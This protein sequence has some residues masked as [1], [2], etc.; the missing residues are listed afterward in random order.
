[1]FEDRAPGWEIGRDDVRVKAVRAL[2]V[3]FE[4]LDEQALEPAAVRLDMEREAAAERLID[5]GHDLPRALVAKP[6]AAGAGQMEIV[7]TLKAL[8]RWCLR[9]GRHT[10]RHRRPADA[11]GEPQPRLP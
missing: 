3:G 1:M 6:P 8:V 5:S 10:A 4:T 9:L 11:R 2:G 7:E